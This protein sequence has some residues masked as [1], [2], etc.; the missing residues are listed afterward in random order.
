[1]KED[2]E[3]YKKCMQQAARLKEDR[4]R[5]KE[6]KA[7]KK[8][9]SFKEKE[10][11]K[12]DAG[13]QSSGVPTFSSH[14]TAVSQLKPVLKWCYLQP[15]TMWRKRSE[16]LV[17]MDAIL[18]S[19]DGGQM[20]NAFLLLGHG[21]LLHAEYISDVFPPAIRGPLYW[22]TGVL[23]ICRPYIP[24]LGPALFEWESL[25]TSTAGIFI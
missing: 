11:R 10:K 20:I 19:I 8:Q 5:E 21:I 22:A 13:M 14:A 24:C 18:G 7:K 16:L 23:S 9:L 1:M 2:V 15:K 3:Y 4:M 25:C 6:E 12:R 17:S